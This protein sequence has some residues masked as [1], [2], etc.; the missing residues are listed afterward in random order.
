MNTFFSKSPI[1]IAGDSI[2][3]IIATIWPW[4]C[5]CW[6]S[7]KDTAVTN[8]TALTEPYAAAIAPASNTFSFLL[9]IKK[10]Y[11]GIISEIAIPNKIDQPI[12]LVNVSCDSSCP[13]LN[14]IANNK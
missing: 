5:N 7:R 6:V 10:V 12:S 2:K 14:P 1:I 11:N 13:P 3:A 9:K 4:I 8:V